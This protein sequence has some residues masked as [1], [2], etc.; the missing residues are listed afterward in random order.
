MFIL[1]VIEDFNTDRIRIRIR[2]KMSWIR[3]TVNFTCF[4]PVMST[5]R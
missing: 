2:T 4:L 1:K 3:N 5:V